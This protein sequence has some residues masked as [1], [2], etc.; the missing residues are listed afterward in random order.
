MHV[1][2]SDV[3]N[4]Y[5][6]TVYDVNVSV[7]FQNL[8]CKALW[9]T[10][11]Y[12]TMWTAYYY[13]YYYWQE[14]MWNWLYSLNFR[15]IFSYILKPE[16]NN[17]AAWEGF[18]VTREAVSNFKKCFVIF[19]LMKI[20]FLVNVCIH[21]LHCLTLPLQHWTHYVWRSSWPKS[22]YHIDLDVAVI[23]NQYRLAI[24]K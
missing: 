14:Q 9:I 12:L 18:S 8:F 11:W 21:L 10:D 3:C 1:L 19:P 24:L 5:V 7:I 13:Y 23:V 22:V 16:V 4:M 15:L 2:L 17:F 6:Y 20:G